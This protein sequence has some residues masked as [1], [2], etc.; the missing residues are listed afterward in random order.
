M[1]KGLALPDPLTDDHQPRA[2][3]ATVKGVRIY[4]L[5]VPNGDRISST[6]F[7]YKLRWLDRLGQELLAGFSPDDA[8]VWDPFRTEGRVLCHPEERAR[9]SR[10]LDWGLVDSFR[11]ANPF[12]SEFSWWDYQKMGWQRGHGMRIDHVLLSRA[13]APRCTEVTIW[14]DTRG[15]K[16]PSDH[17]PVTVDLRD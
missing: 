13:L 1:Q 15:W 14:R 16:Q 2:I 4:G 5:Y 7:A 11:E 17:A 12:A 9:F 6:K 8:D 10:L 3:A